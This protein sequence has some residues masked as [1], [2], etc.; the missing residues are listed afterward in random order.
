MAVANIAQSVVRDCLRLKEDEPVI[1]TTYP[2]TM[3]LAN[4]LAIEC[5][6]VGADPFIQLETDEWFYGQFKH[7]TVEQLR[8]TSK[9]CLGLNDY[10]AAYISLGGPK[11]PAPMK[12]V[13]KE[14]FTAMFQG[15]QGHYEAALQK[16]SSR[17]V[18]IALGQVTK[19]RAKTYGF[20]H[21]AWMKNV[22]DALSVKYVDLQN[23]GKHLAGY[24]SGSGDAHLTAPNGTDLRF[25]LDS[26]RVHVYDGIIDDE[27]LAKDSRFASL[28]AGEVATTA[29]ETS[30]NGMVIF[31]VATPQVGLMIQNM[32][33]TFK[34]GHLVDFSARKNV[35]ATKAFYDAASGGKDMLSSIGI[36]I[37]PRAKPSFLHAYLA[38]GAV[39]VGIGENREL[40]GKVQ[41]DY[42]FA[43]TL[44]KATVDVAGKRI[45]EKGRIIV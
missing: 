4:Q 12:K 9:H 18:S 45:V 1:I 31:D 13:P 28:P 5:Y 37:N 17:S 6:K 27:D 35:E 2:H 14:R 3:D 11:D 39:S 10:V 25:R 26:R 34:D 42:E 29:D 8:K 24:L 36:G 21:S 30:A 19:E 7:L 20:P 23:K 40:G 22:T 41:S 43:G 33:W 15:E 38:A 32:S 16:K 44:S